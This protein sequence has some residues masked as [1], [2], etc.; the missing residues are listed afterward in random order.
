MDCGVGESVL[1]WG[2]FW[3]GM[4]QRS[5]G[6]CTKKGSRREE[7]TT[8]TQRTRRKHLTAESA[9]NAEKIFATEEHGFARK[10]L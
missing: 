7:F 1:G 3:L 10:R 4:L 6:K 5:I 2:S 9:K 8:E